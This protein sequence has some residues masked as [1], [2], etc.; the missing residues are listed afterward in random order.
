MLKLCKL[1]RI[2]QKSK[3][4]LKLNYEI[5]VN[6]RL[7][8]NGLNNSKT[9]SQFVTN[10]KE[11]YT[12]SLIDPI[13]MKS[14]FSNDCFSEV[15]DKSCDNTRID[16][17]KL[18]FETDRVICRDSDGS[19]SAFII[20]KEGYSSSF[21][22]RF[23]CKQENWYELS[24]IIDDEQIIHITMNVKGKTHQLN[25]HL[26]PK[27]TL[28]Y[29]GICPNN[30]REDDIF[31]TMNYKYLDN[32]NDYPN[33]FIFRTYHLIYNKKTIFTS[34]LLK[35]LYGRT[36]MGFIFE[37]SIEPLYCVPNAKGNKIVFYNINNSQKV[38]TAKLFD[39]GVYPGFNF[40][41]E[42]SLING[43]LYYVICG[44][45]TKGKQRIEI[46]KIDIETLIVLDRLR[47]NLDL[48]S[49]CDESYPIRIIENARLIQHNNGDIGLLEIKYSELFYIKSATHYF[50]R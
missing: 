1:D 19:P 31:F 20:L 6:L 29:L 12:K 3:L 34:I 47:L 17:S 7:G 44:V 39:N 4:I 38:F 45:I 30:V 43:R 37:N 36:L 40:L 27:T 49:T 9:L 15:I 14:L 5:V 16:A 21:S 41:G 18:N 28:G 35:K 46:F 26:G 23:N 50:V 2:K 33:R 48:T 11:K 8:I 13:I 24:G 22:F 32:T 42:F 10:V 25:I